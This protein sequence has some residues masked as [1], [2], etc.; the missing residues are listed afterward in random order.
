MHRLSSRLASR[1]LALMLAALALD[2]AACG[3][4]PAGKV[5]VSS[6]V[7]SFQAPDAEDFDQDTD[8]DDDSDT[9]SADSA[10]AD[11]GE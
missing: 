1:T 8:D 3:P 7:Y 11:G 6:P 5:P 4:N 10:D 2:A 9:D